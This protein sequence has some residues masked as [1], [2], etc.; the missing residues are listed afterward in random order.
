[1][2]PSRHISRPSLRLVLNPHEIDVSAVSRLMALVGMRERKRA[3]MR[4]AI[5]A[6]SDFIVAYLGGELVGFGRMISDRTYYGS[7]W[8]V[9]VRPDLQKRGIGTEIIKRLLKRAEKRKL[10]MVGLF[11]GSHNRSFYEQCGFE[12]IEDIHAMRM[13]LE[14]GDHY[15]GQAKGLHHD[16]SNS[17]HNNRCR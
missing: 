4:R 16:K 10:Y 3:D 1:M 12:F 7:I 15:N 6:S 14:A 8:D 9:A 5:L 13:V 17:T 2:K 11:T